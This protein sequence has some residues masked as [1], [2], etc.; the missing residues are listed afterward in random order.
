MLWTSQAFLFNPFEHVSS[1]QFVLLLA[2]GKSYL[3]LRL[4]TL[5]IIERFIAHQQI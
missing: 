2:R 1:R 4:E 3:F 5:D